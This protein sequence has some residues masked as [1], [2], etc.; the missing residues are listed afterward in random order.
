VTVSD[1]HIEMTLYCSHV[2]DEE[3]VQRTNI[4]TDKYRVFPKFIQ[5]I[6]MFYY[7]PC[8]AL[9][10]VKFLGDYLKHLIY[11]RKPPLFRLGENVIK[12]F[13]KW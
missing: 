12:L 2:T 4:V 9:I 6:W 13:S 11:E 1:N 10:N 7:F 8:T 5:Q 3:S